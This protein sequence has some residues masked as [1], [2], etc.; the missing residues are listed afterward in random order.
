MSKPYMCGDDKAIYIPGE[1]SCECAY[2]LAQIETDEYAAKYKLLLDGEQVGDAINVP[3]DK[4]V[5]SGEVKTVVAD[6][7]PYQGASAGDQY[8]DL[9]ISNSDDHV[10]IP[11][12]RT[13]GKTS[14][15]DTIEVESSGGGETYSSSLLNDTFAIKA[16]TNVYFTFEDDGFTVNASNSGA[17]ASFPVGSVYI[18]NS[19]SKDPSDFLGGTWTC[20]DADFADFTQW[21]PDT[22]SY[23][24]FNSTYTN[25]NSGDQNVWQQRS[26][27]E[28]YSRIQLT[29]TA[30]IND[31]GA[32]L[33]TFNQ[34]PGRLER[35]KNV[36]L[37]SDGGNARVQA[38][39]DTNGVVT[40][41]DVLSRNNTAVSNTLTSGNTLTGDFSLPFAFTQSD[42]LNTMNTT[43]CNKFYWRRTA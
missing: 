3:K 32:V 26:D 24:S 31:N 23:V 15:F 25:T 29:L 6:N 37:A 2:T 17:L 14:A 9:T 42:M 28:W 4:V 5:D 34:L 40:A 22:D 11:L 30:D 20:Y 41:H 35:N 10:Y 16:G 8:I 27:H 18:T 39:L 1:G 36:S 43:L 12:V 7:V 33:F 19:I 21:S 13:Q 38:T